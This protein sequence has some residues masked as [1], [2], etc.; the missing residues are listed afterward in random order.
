MTIC[1]I[2]TKHTLMGLLDSGSQF[3]IKRSDCVEEFTEGK[4]V[5][6]R[7]L[8]AGSR[9]ELWGM[10]EKRLL[11]VQKKAISKILFESKQN[12]PVNVWHAI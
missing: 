11:R 5:H 3:K 9:F 8:Q 2:E 6:A 1:K 7:Q 10:P 4:T 12:L